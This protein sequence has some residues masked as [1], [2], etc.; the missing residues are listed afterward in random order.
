MAAE[1]IKTRSLYSSGKSESAL[2]S[3]LIQV[4]GSSFFNCSSLEQKCPLD[5]V[6]TRTE[7]NTTV[8]HGGTGLSSGT[9]ASLV[10]LRLFS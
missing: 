4:S 8:K 3:S 5:G 1:L 6:L 2:Y 10:I 7:Y 9:I